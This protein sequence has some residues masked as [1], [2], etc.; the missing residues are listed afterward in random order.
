MNRII[1]M[2][3]VILTLV[4]L[5]LLF[6]NRMLRGKHQGK[7]KQLKKSQFVLSQ[8]QEKLMEK[9]VISSQFQKE[10]KSGMRKLNEEIF[11][12][13]KTLFDLLPKK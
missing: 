10:H 8:K 7:M 12:L 9:I 5:K 6:A 11:F 4:V 1:I 2:T 3:F 13:Q